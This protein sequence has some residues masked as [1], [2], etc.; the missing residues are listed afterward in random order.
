MA[1]VP[2]NVSFD[3]SPVQFRL[4]SP[5]LACFDPLALDMI[6]DFA[7]PGMLLDVAVLL[8]RMNAH[9]SAMACYTIPHFHPGLFT[10]DPHDI[11]KFG[12]EDEDFD[13]GEA[14]EQQAE[15]GDK[16]S[17]CPWVGVDS[18]TLI[19]ADL[20]HLPEFGKVLTWETYDLAL[21]HEEVFGEIV[22][23]L[24]GPF[25]AVMH[26]SCLPRDGVRWRWNVHYSSSVRAAL[27]RLT[28]RS[29]RQPPHSVPARR[30]VPA[31]AGAGELSRHAAWR[32]QS[33][34]ARYGLQQPWA[35]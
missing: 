26:G 21:Q 7:P 29:I 8:K 11:K 35:D 6:H 5:L 27:R 3:G 2:T 4:D 16:S 24:G 23:A 14:E 25:F 33:R 10:L 1:T 32:W 20:A 22:H 34:D 18:G 12:D 30:H 19:V 13:Y 28:N 9:H 17:S 15:A 31:A